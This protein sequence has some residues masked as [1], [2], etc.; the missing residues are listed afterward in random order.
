MKNY[1]YLIFPK[2]LL[3]WKE[4]F[5]LRR[6]L[7][8]SK[9]DLGM[10]YISLFAAVLTFIVFSGFFIA[11]GFSCRSLGLNTLD[12]LTLSLFPIGGGLL[13]SCMFFFGDRWFSRVV[14]FQGGQILGGGGKYSEIKAFQIG[15]VPLDGKEIPILTLFYKKNVKRAFVIDPKV[16][17]EQ[18]KR[19]LES[20][21]SLHSTCN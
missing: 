3:R 1:N 6:K 5:E 10:G 7:V 19:L 18:L 4:P 9:P 8:E 13:I 14:T 20:K 17:L 15:S 16:D 21:V 2:T 11:L 12:S